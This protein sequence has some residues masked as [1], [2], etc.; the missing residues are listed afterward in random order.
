MVF[1]INTLSILES[2]AEIADKLTTEEL[3]IS[4]IEYA[5]VR[6]VDRIGKVFSEVLGEETHKE[7]YEKIIQKIKG[8]K[9]INPSIV[10]KYRNK[11][12]I[13]PIIVAKD[14]QELKS[15]DLPD[16][17]H[18]EDSNIIAV[19]H[20]F[21]AILNKGSD[22]S[23]MSDFFDEHDLDHKIEEI[24]NKLSAL[25]P[26]DKKESPNP[27]GFPFGETE[28]VDWHDYAT[29][30]VE[31]A[32]EYKK[33]FIGRAEI[34]ENAIRS[35]CRMEKCNPCLV[36]EP[37]VGK[38]AITKGVAKM[39]LDDKVPN[40]I[41]GSKFYSVDLAGMVAGSKYRGE[42]EERLKALLKG[43][44]EESDKVILFFDE[45]HTIVGA[46]ATSSGAM[47]ASNIIKPY[48]TEGKIKFIGATTYDEY[49]QY[50]EKDKALERRFQ[51]ID[52]TEPTIDDTIKIL[53]G[54]KEAYEEY[55]G[56][57]YNKNAIEAAVKLSVK[58]INDRFLP[59]K[60]IDLIDEAGAQHA[61]HPELGNKVT[62]ND[63]ENIL[64]RLCN[65]P[66]LTSEVDELAK[67]KTL[68][69]KIKSLVFG[70]DHAID[71]MVDAI[72]L[73]KSGL[74]D[75]EK[76]IGSFLLVGPSGVGKTEVAKQLANQLGI[77]FI[78]FD[79]SEYQ[80]KHT[81]SK[82]IGAPAG[83]AG[84][85]DGGI[86][87]E[88]IRKTPHCVLLL[89]EIEKAHPDI[90]KSFLQVMDYGKLTDSHGRKADFRHAIIIMTSNAGATVATKKSLGFTSSVGNDINTDGINTA[91]ES[92]FTPEFRNRLTKIV[93]F[94]GINEEI[95]KKVV[96]KELRILN[97]KLK[98]KK[99]SA[100][101]TD[102]CIQE[103]LNRGVSKEFGAR[104]LQR[105][106]NENI[107]KMF[108][109]AI[110]DGKDL[111][112]CTVDYVDGKFCIT[113]KSMITKKSK[114][115]ESV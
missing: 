18:D 45:I 114:I 112:N 7:L 78:R 20:L 5:M 10:L 36:G 1:S 26:I 43:V 87:T 83:Y 77:A 37:G 32:K 49:R 93:V 70:Q 63:I 76:P 19:Q 35:L 79:M 106:I 80:E 84:Y 12:E 100:S 110:I 105:C 2:A 111:K 94:N 58:Y 48:L 97:T 42:F 73:S 96:E 92:T 113:N 8:I 16:I 13:L 81:V 9:K 59:D 115:I 27:F 69:T 22:K 33:P 57:K 61:V 11:G 89:D 68:D 101:Y 65:I 74:G 50:I 62:K 44:L 38:T 41:K 4:H 47:D 56:I 30:L 71:E 98:A 64:S 29:D 86:L 24:Y 25:D 23:V 60:A 17:A 104:G 3:N 107:K 88:A 21:Q 109:E 108:V 14:V 55:H 31:A 53:D 67:V 103:L 54:L 102:A 39:I 85:E 6:G 52:V 66:K 75:E 40:K 91:V 95:G 15:F 51:K 82:L 28:Q 90:Y 72:K 34:I 46:G 99:I